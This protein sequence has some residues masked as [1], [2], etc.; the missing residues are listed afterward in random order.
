MNF[1]VRYIGND[2][3]EMSVDEIDTGTMDKTEAIK[4]A[5][6][7]LSA[8]DLLLYGAGLRVS[9]DICGGLSEDLNDFI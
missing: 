9:S 3:Q 4:Q 8:C 1:N 2:L 7:M 6:K 5:Q